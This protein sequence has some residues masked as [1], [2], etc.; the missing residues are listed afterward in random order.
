MAIL[1]VFTVTD[2][3]NV[4]PFPPSVVASA[5]HQN[6]EEYTSA[7]QPG[8]TGLFSTV[9]TPITAEFGAFFFNNTDELTA[10]MNEHTLTDSSFIADIEAW[11][12]AHSVTYQHNIYNIV[13]TG[14]ST[15]K[16]I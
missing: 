8:D 10:W 14:E 13:D 11:K 9:V 5:W 3:N 2:P 12:V 4:G 16:F 1:Y 7:H 15:P 6:V